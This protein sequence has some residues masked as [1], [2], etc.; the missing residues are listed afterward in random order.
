M[1]PPFGLPLERVV[2]K[3][4]ATICGERFEAGTVVGISGWVVHRDRATFG[5][6]VDVW[7]PERWLVGEEERRKMEHALLTVG[8][9]PVPLR[10]R[11]CFLLRPFLYV[12]GLCGIL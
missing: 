5:E 7:R 12:P 11:R 3:G 9:F 2:P 1:H 4:G 8:Y 6:D 10:L